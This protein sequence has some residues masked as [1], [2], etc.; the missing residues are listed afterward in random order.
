M[1][2]GASSYEYTWSS[3]NIVLCFLKL[4][5]GCMKVVLFT[6]GR[7]IPGERT[8]IFTHFCF[9]FPEGLIHTH[10]RMRNA[11]VNFCFCLFIHRTLCVCFRDY[12]GLSSFRKCGHIVSYLINCSKKSSKIL[13]HSF[14]NVSASNVLNDAI[15]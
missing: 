8:L 6:P 14:S 10:S 15:L 7:F 9:K 13:L 2:N 4:S 12:A 5:T 11:T 3:A 1:L